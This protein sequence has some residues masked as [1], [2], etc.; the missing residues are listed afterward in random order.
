MNLSGIKYLTP[1]LLLLVSCSVRNDDV[2]IPE[3]ILSHKEIVKIITD[4]YL[5]EGATGINVKAVTGQNIDSVYL[6]NPLKDN[7][8]AK[9]KFDSSIL[10]YSK[11]PILFK[12]VYDDV[13]E[14]LNKIAAKGKLWYIILMK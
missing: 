9:T 1:I 6:F 7:R 13:L 10:F 11:H 8:C 2:I 5:A 3:S 12:Q 4:C 14:Q